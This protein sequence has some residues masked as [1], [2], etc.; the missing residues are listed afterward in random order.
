MEMDGYHLLNHVLSS[1]IEEDVSLQ[2]LQTQYCHNN[3]EEEPKMQQL[4]ATMKVVKCEG[5]ESECWASV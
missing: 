4:V 2:D 5:A 1:K 3:E